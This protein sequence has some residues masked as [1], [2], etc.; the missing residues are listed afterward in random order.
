MRRRGQA[1]M[2]PPVAARIAAAMLVGAAALCGAGAPAPGRDEQLPDGEDR[3]RFALGQVVFR[4]QWVSA[5]ASTT[6][7]DGLGPL[8]NA[9]ACAQCHLGGGRGQPPTAL[10]VRLSVPPR[11]PAERALLAERKIKALPEPTYGMQLQAFA[12]QGHRSEGRIEVSYEEV[13]VVLGDG[14]VVRLRKPSYRLAALGYGPLRDDVAISPR[15]APSL[16]GLGLIEMVPEEQ[17]LE[18]VRGP[19]EGEGVRGVAGRIWSQERGKV[20]L[21]RF[22]WKA[23]GPTLRQQVAEAFAVDLGISSSLVRQPAGDC[24]AQ[25]VQCQSAA[26]GRSTRY[27]GHELADA[28]LDL[29]TV[30]VASADLPIRQAAV[31]EAMREGEAHFHAAG[32]AE[33]HRPSFTTSSTRGPA[34]LRGR[35]IW[36]FTDLLLHDMGEDLADAQPGPAA[37]GRMW[38]TAP[39]WEVGRAQTPDGRQTF[40]HDGRARSVVEAVLWHGGEARAARDAFARL[41]AAERGALIAFVESL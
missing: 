29:V 20:V 30:Y 4:R 7:S 10:V 36:P 33:C 35:V 9:R 19:G 6:A 14:E 34:H 24:T 3:F 40:L 18:R 25:Q 21:G 5:P 31:A 16:V 26:D 15:V 8:Y 11:T 2:A 28:V 27:G 22:G 23:D 13:S 38:R 39:L 1:L 17:V 41:T 37:D 12:I 32:C